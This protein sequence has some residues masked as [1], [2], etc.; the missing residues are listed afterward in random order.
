ML[1]R[2]DFH[3]IIFPP[4]L[5]ICILSTAYKGFAIVCVDGCVIEENQGGC[6]WRKRMAV[7][8]VGR[9]QWL[10]KACLLLLPALPRAYLPLLDHMDIL[11]QLKQDEMACIYVFGRRIHMF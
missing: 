2:T 7:A 8:T 11:L 10:P 9:G 1:S 3:P 4:S 5:P 6:G